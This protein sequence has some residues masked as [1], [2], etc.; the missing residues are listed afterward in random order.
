MI[1]ATNDAAAHLAA[2]P[3]HFGISQNPV[4]IVTTLVNGEDLNK[5][6]HFGRALSE[7][8][9]NRL[10]QLEFAVKEI[11]LRQS[12]LINGNEG[13]LM[14]SRELQKIGRELNA[15]AVVVGT[16]T[17]GAEYVYVSIKLIRL[18]DSQV[19]S[20]HNFRLLR[21]MDIVGL[22]HGIVPQQPITP[23]KPQKSHRN[24]LSG[25]SGGDRESLVEMVGNQEEDRA[26]YD[27]IRDYDANRGAY[28][29]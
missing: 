9:G 6:S 13:E 5:S 10:A 1:T 27:I 24:N 11:R 20:A 19:V 17:E 7:Q 4:T 22:L 23:P 15:E 8:V 25:F 18:H 16:Y 12:V 26:L 3:P 2:V 14:L 28:M 29:E 21:T